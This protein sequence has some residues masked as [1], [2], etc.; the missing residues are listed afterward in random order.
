MHKA[1]D[2]VEW[3]FL[4]A[5]MENIGFD[6]RWRSTILGCISS[7]N[8]A[9]LLNEQPG[10]KFVPLQGLQQGDPLSPYLFLM[11][12]EVFSLRIQQA[13]DRDWIKGVHMNP[14]GPFISHILFADDTFICLKAEKENCQHLTHLIDDYN[15]AYGQQVNKSKSSVF[16]RSNVPK[17]LSNQ[18]VSTLSMVRVRDPGVYLGVPAI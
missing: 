7:V 2:M 18:L 5:V 4:S 13:S 12:S 17:S 15:L 8:F 11:F 16:F 10:P 14:M 6:S 3:D 1:Y 9:I